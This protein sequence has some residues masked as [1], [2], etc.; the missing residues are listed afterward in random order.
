MAYRPTVQLYK[1]LGFWV[2]CLK[3]SK[4]NLLLS[5]DGNNDRSPFKFGAFSVGRDSI[6][7]AAQ[8]ILGTVSSFSVFC[9]AEL[10]WNSPWFLKSE[11]R[12]QLKSSLSWNF[13]SW[14]KLSRAEKMSS[15]VELSWGISNQ[16]LSQNRADWVYM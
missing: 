3:T 4:R 8:Y 11:I 6:G 1:K 9:F 12:V 5:S 10:V 14:A 13:P 16:F 2:S 15:Q 7:Q